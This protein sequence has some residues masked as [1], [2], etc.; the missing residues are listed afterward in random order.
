MGT[1][2]RQP[3][4][5]GGGVDRRHWTSIRQLLPTYRAMT[6][7]DLRDGASTSFWEDSWLPDGPLAKIL[8][9][10]HSHAIRPVVPLRTVLQ[11]GWTQFSSPA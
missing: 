5:A 4:H 11:Q 6:T 7:V 9:A 10:L 2:A 8:P 1:A 3:G